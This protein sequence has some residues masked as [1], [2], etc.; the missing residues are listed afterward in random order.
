MK[1]TLS[2]NIKAGHIIKTSN[3]WRKVK[4]VTNDEVIG[5]EGLVK[6]EST[7]FGFREI[8]DKEEKQ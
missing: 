8:P 1:L 6:Y 7:I 3:G 2:R 4:E 5:K